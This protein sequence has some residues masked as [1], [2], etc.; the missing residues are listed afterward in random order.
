MADMVDCGYHTFKA[1]ARQNPGP[2]T[3]ICWHNQIFGEFDP[4]L[5]ADEANILSDHVGKLEENA[6]KLFMRGWEKAQ[7]EYFEI[8]SSGN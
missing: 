6:Q 4:T 5:S 2:A 7:E 8:R 3:G 1:W